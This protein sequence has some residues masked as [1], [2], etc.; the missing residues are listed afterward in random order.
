MSAPT[1]SDCNQDAARAHGS[2][3]QR[4]VR[5]LKSLERIWP[6][7]A[8]IIT[9]ISSYGEITLYDRHPEE[10]GRAVASFRIRCDS[11]DGERTKVQFPLR[12]RS[13]KSPNESSSATAADGDRGAQK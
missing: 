9:E 12:P 10:G 11:V 7:D 8:V 4:L 5:R 3:L 1:T 2:S 6:R 13:A